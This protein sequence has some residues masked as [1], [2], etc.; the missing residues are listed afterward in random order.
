MF[1]HYHVILRELVIIAWPSYTSILN[2][3]VGN[4]I[5]NLGVSNLN[6]KLYYNLFLLARQPPVGQGLHIHEFSRSHT[7][8]HHS[9]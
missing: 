3:A 2:A 7:T 4:T 6:Y 8:T 1:R 5:Y 9:R